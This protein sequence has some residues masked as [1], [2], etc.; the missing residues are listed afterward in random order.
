M[1]TRNREKRAAKQKA[2][3]RAERAPSGPGRASTGAEFP[4]AFTPGPD[5]AQRQEIL[6]G[7]LLR[8]ASCGCG[9]DP[10]GHAAE[11][12]ARVDGPVGELD[13]AA[14]LAVERTIRRIWEFGW[15][16]FDV[17]ELARRRAP[18]PV[19]EYLAE[20]IVFESRRY[21]PAMVHPRWRA[22]VDAIAATLDAAVASE[23]GSA[24]LR[25][26][27][28]RAAADRA[29]AVATVL[30]ALGLLGTLPKLER[31]VPL[32]GESRHR[33]AAPDAGDVDQKVLG[34]VRGLLAKAEST[35][36]PD[37]AEALSAK[38]QDLMSRY[39]LHQAVLDHDS[40]RDPA[41]SGRRI[42]LDA[43]YADA[44]ALLVQTVAAANRCRTVWSSG[45]GFATVIGAEVDLDSVE[46]LVTSLLV[47]ANRA[48]LAAGRH[49]T[50][51]GTSRTR[52][53]RQSFIVAYATR[54]GERLESATS[55]ATAE[56]DAEMRLVEP[57]LDSRLLPVLAARADATEELTERLFP[58]MVQRGVS[59]SNRAGLVAGRAAADLA[60]FDVRG[61]VAR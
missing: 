49:I 28:E 3:R 12:L 4:F 25:L 47:Q 59:A 9:E 7:D 61:A 60:Q 35:E 45:L 6:V 19:G 5:R 56:I 29:S 39:S 32:P 50:R 33:V 36:F 8:S 2:R 15:M 20:A 17:V 53:F 51:S 1:S 31:L 14:D 42:W 23:A 41:V 24:H 11:L 46:L 26:W 27:A 22:A 54:I 13:T 52:S 34:K 16:P 30:Q 38:A 55:S 43:P 10:A 40:G 58:E 57:E 18:A 44:K 37:E 48:M 21:A